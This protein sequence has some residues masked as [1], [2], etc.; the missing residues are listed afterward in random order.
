MDQW[1]VQNCCPNESFY[2]DISPL[3]IWLKLRKQCCHIGY[4]LDL[5][6][7]YSFKWSIY[8]FC[9]DVIIIIQIPFQYLFFKK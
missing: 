1:L 5:P 6:K 3:D 9:N 4:S 8:L 7:V 2:V